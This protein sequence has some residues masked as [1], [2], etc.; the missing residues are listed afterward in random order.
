MVA[1]VLSIVPGIAM[2]VV[3]I[4]RNERTVFSLLE[5]GKY[6]IALNLILLVL[7][8]MDMDRLTWDCR[9][10]SAFWN[11]NQDRCEEGYS[12]YVIGIAILFTVQVGGI[13]PP[14]TFRLTHYIDGWLSC[15]P[16]W[17]LLSALLCSVLPPLS[18]AKK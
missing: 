18:Y 9:F 3:Q 15:L 7:G 4:I 1:A 16:L 11:P 12:N 8:A 5:T 10:H 13:H 17:A 2:V 14:Q 6:G